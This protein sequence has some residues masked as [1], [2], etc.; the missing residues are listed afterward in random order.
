MKPDSMA[1]TP[2][3][4]ES[5]VDQLCGVVQV[6][7]AG[8]SKTGSTTLALIGFL[9]IYGTPT[10]STVALGL[11]FADGR[12]PV[13]DL[14]A[15]GAH[16]YPRLVGC[17]AAMALMVWVSR[18]RHAWLPWMGAAGFIAAGVMALQIEVLTAA[19]WR[20]GVWPDSN[21]GLW[22]P[23]KMMFKLWTSSVGL[24]L[25]A[26][27][28]SVPFVIAQAADAY[29]ARPRKGARRKME[30]GAAGQGSSPAA[31]VASRVQRPRLRLD[32]LAGMSE[33]KAQLRE[34]IAPFAG[35]AS[36]GAPADTNGLLLAGPPGN[37]KTVFAEAVAGELGFGFLKIGVQDLTSKFVNESPERIQRAFAE[38]I[39]AQPCVLFLDE[40][41][42]VG[43]KRGAKMGNSNGED[44][45]VVDTLLT[46]ID[47]LRQHRVLLVAA[48]NH[49]DELDEA[50]VR[51]GRFD[52]KIE[53]PLPDAPAR[54]GILAAM[55]KKY[56]LGASAQT[57]ARVAQMWER[58]SAAFIEAVCK[59]VR[60]DMARQ[61]QQEADLVAFK[62][63]AR[64]VSRREGAIPK[65]GVPLSKLVLPEAT[66]RDAQS[67]VY[68]L[69]NWE[70]LAERGGSP[71]KGVLLYGP[72]G[73][74]KTNLVRAIALELGDWH[75][76]EVKT[77][78]ILAD[79]RRF[80][81][82]IDKACEHRPAIVFI[83]EADDLLRDRSYS[84]NATATNE[85]LKSMDGMMGAV[86]E[87]VFFAATNNQDAIDAAAKRGGRFAEKLFLDVLRGEDLAA[88]ACTELRRRPN[89]Q[90]TDDITAQWIAQAV[91]EI[92]PADLIATLDKAV[93]ATLV[94]D[95]SR[96]VGRK[97]FADA[98][99]AIT[100]RSVA[101]D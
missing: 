72:P 50:L 1:P 23:A 18:V 54:E 92:G 35:Y 71:P 101:R 83:D 55:S 24:V 17:I 79:P 85:I 99:A 30:I 91:G 73:T 59:R 27:T 33:L 12:S 63:A 15:A 96:P 7:G 100:E 19:S 40:F 88:F 66:R 75:V 20:V 21:S 44:V 94:D 77:A 9:A 47:K 43:M 65:T 64:A 42:A 3:E 61:G 34:F 4:R 93:N 13:A 32:D 97:D 28:F 67:I 98:F 6:I 48:T 25:L 5:Y 36:G 74:G 49:P 81:D 56:R 68:R 22:E 69:R 39:A 16:A 80:Q 41:D 90:F 8:A 29:A 14:E 11:L 87:V 38:A 31:Q 86:P 37:G 84:P 2:E 46:E 26:G 76:F 45:K 58:R 62:A 95:H 53:I 10:F 57:V 70:S 52:R 78:D 82:V 89:V 51:P 60:D